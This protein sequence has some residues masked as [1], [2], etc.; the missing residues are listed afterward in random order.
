MLYLQYTYVIF[1]L[2][3]DASIPDRIEV[4]LNSFIIDFYIFTFVYKLEFSI[5]GY[6]YSV[7]IYNVMMII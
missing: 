1:A 3:I 7:F 6:A 4:K 2:N 5:N